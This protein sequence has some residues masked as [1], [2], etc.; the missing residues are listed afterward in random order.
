MGSTDAL[1][2][3][4][5][6]SF[7][8]RMDAD[9]IA[10]YNKHIAI[11]PPTHAIDLSEV[12]ANPQKWASPWCK[13]YADLPFV[14]D[15]QITSGD[16]HVFTARI[17]S[18]DDNDTEPGSGPYP[19][20]VNF[21]GGGYC[22]GDLTSD[23]ALLMKIR[24]RARI[25]VVDVDYRLTPE[26]AFGKGTDDAWAAVQWVH[27]HA[28]EIN[29]RPDSIS[30]GGISAGGFMSCVLQQLA[31]DAGLPLKLAILSV[32]STHTRKGIAK[33]EDSPFPSLAENALAP[34]LNWKRVRFFAA[35]VQ[36]SM[37]D[38]EWGALPL[39]R[40]SPIEAT[41]LEGVCD[42][43]IATAGCDPLRDEGE[44]YGQKLIE[45]GVKVTVRRYTGVPH[46]WM[47]ME[48]VKKADM[49]MDDLCQALVTAHR[50]KTE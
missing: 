25:I 36:K 37:S 6:P 11:K 34:C 24:K 3:P 44:A 4:I 5:D 43:F 16:G 8:D 28:H 18:P 13:D 31:R 46:P 17:Y 9:F 23:A 40:R 27:A 48:G 19:V 42:T 32:P 47:H 1:P 49:Y 22:F 12:R 39:F 2:N 45:A 10:Y 15:I 35:V 41:S 26:H 21:H 14:H 38:E 7:I 30:I 33:P 50:V 29:G 20:H